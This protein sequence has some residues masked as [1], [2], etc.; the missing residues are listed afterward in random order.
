MK[1][2][3]KIREKREERRDLRGRKEPKQ[4]QEGR[5]G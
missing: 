5:R 2:A 1:Q 3:E 4:I